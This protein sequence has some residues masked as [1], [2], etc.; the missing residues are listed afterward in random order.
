MNPSKT[1]L[2]GLDGGASKVRGWEIKPT[3]KGFDFE[4]TPIENKYQDH[5][6]YLKDF[7]PVNLN[8]LL[9]EKAYGKID[10][11]KNEIEY[12]QVITETIAKTILDL[13]AQRTGKWVIGIGFPGLKT[14]DKRGISAMANGPRMPNLVSNI[15]NILDHEK[16]DLIDR[17]HQLGS[18]ADFCGLGENEGKGGHFK[19]IDNAY[20]IGGGTGVA[21]ALKLHGQL[22]PFDQTQDWLGKSWEMEMNGVPIES[23]LSVRGIQEQYS[24]VTGTHINELSKNG[25]Y[26][27]Q[28]LEKAQNNDQQAKETLAETGKNLGKLFFERIETIACGWQKRFNFINPERKDLIPE[29]DY[30]GTCLDQG[31]I[32]Q[33]L[34]ELLSRDI[35][36]RI[37]RQELE[38]TIFFMMA[39]TDHLPR[40]FKSNFNPKTFFRISNLRDAPALGAGISAWKTFM[41]K[42]NA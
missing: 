39:N 35:G 14:R 2:L 21:D 13:V 3:S 27:Q 19:N 18:D 32:G 1:R 6:K 34:G 23:L 42:N 29:H 26:A 9:S 33:R 10:P 37:I 40:T 5:P 12:G 38:N 25:L 28:I 31:I 30:L 36:S 11:Q 15:E 4:G 16:I 41:K 20:Y 7:S 8:Q 22:V 17:I 24:I